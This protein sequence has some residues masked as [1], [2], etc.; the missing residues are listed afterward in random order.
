MWPT[1]EKATFSNNGKYVA[2][3]LRNEP[4]GNSTLFVKSTET[5]WAKQIKFAEKFSF[6]NDS[7]Y[8]G[9]ISNDTLCVYILGKGRAVM[10]PN[11]KK[12]SFCNYKGKS[13]LAYIIGVKDSSSFVLLNIPNHTK[14]ILVDNI[15]DFVYI[16]KSESFILKA[17]S[18]G[19]I[20]K[21]DTLSIFKTSNLESFQFWT[22][23]KVDNVVASNSGRN[24]AIQ[25]SSTLNGKLYRSIWNYNI[26]SMKLTM[27]VDERD[28][29]F[30]DSL[31][32]NVAYPLKYA[33]NDK[34]L[35]LGTKRK[36]IKRQPPTAVM[37]D[38]WGYKDAKLQSQQLKE[39][40]PK[41]QMASYDLKNK[42][43][44]V[45]ESEEEKVLSFNIFEAFNSD[46][47]LL[48]RLLG[49]EEEYNW[50]PAGQQAVYLCCLKD[51][52]KILLQDRINF[53]YSYFQLSP[54]GKF[55]LFYDYDNNQYNSYEIYT[56]IRRN[57]TP[58]SQT[59][60]VNNGLEMPGKRNVVG[61]ASW[62]DN[63]ECVYVYDDFDIWRLDLLGLK[64][65]ENI[66]N[67]YGAKNEIEFRFLTS[68]EKMPSKGTIVIRAFD[69]KTKNSGFFRASLFGADPKQLYMGQFAFSIATSVTVSSSKTNDQSAYIVKRMTASESPNFYLT[70]DFKIFRRISSVGPE[71][72]YNWLTDTLI[73]WI[74]PEGNQSQ[75]ILYKPEDFDAAKK[76]PVIF[77]FYEKLSDRL[78][79][80]LYPSD[81]GGMID[82]PWFVSHGY[83]VFTP[84]I[85][86]RIGYPG[87][88]ALS[89]VISAANELKKFNYVDS[90][91]LGLMG[92][93]FG[94]YQVNYI[95][96]H[97]N[98]FSAAAASSGAVDLISH[99]GSI[100]GDGK[101]KR[102]ITET[103]Q[104]RIGSSLWQSPDLYESNS[105]V[106]FAD[107]VNT[108]LLIMHNK[109]DGAVSFAQGLEWFTSL[110]RLRKKA[111][112]LQYDDGDHQLSGESALDYNTRLFQF[113]NHYLRGVSAPK[114]MTNGIPASKKG[115]DS[116]LELDNTGAIP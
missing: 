111:W 33:D 17:V 36:D 42:K 6:S 47:I 95:V 30:C 79:E 58:N 96:S 34:Y 4:I 77:H 113:F 13:Y 115:I 59:A 98:V 43:L 8:W 90:S 18:K 87:E 55:V 38:V 108:P 31:Q 76:Y 97:T 29:A 16:K 60:F 66:T 11:V 110:R 68:K 28:V 21:Y 56:G 99:S 15:N 82:I 39:L 51:G 24:V 81:G 26:D 7:Q 22:G 114:W 92:H 71:K 70:T 107:R 103:S 74:T 73:T 32:I 78:N 52:S 93:S 62:G 46:Y 45:L 116:G 84:D 10:L 41:N 40:N 57:L 61:L 83:L 80:F 37:V 104:S 44:V 94:A 1:L 102:F 35:F 69:F 9:F 106:F 27:L 85:H 3:I 5:N 20:K 23:P 14:E 2:F 63:G 25:T 50:N 91:R 105:P 72:N 53:K 19:T 54:N 12:F 112:L 64:A 49:D 65:P 86:Y 101:A 89:C 67:F 109:L 88:S 75:G 100:M 48:R